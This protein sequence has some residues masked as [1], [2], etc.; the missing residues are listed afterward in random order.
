MPVKNFIQ[1]TLRKYCCPLMLIATYSWVLS[2]KESSVTPV[3]KM[4]IKSCKANSDVKITYS[5]GSDGMKTMGE[6]CMAEKIIA[7]R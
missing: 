5:K 4:S 1:A 7:N 6:L 2:C 3:V